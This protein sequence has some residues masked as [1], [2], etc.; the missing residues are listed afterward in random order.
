MGFSTAS[1][2]LAEGQQK[3]N[4]DE[5]LASQIQNASEVR[6]S[7]MELLDREEMLQRLGMETQLKEKRIVDLRKQVP[8]EESGDSSK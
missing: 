2:L 5:L 7:H 6:P 1:D 8:S 3:D 4:I